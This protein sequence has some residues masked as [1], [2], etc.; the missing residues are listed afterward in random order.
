LS[1]IEQ[2]LHFKR[3]HADCI[4][5]YLKKSKFVISKIKE[6]DLIIC[7]SLLAFS[8][9]FFKE[10]MAHQQVLKMTYVAVVALAWA[11]LFYNYDLGKS[12]IWVLTL[13]TAVNLYKLLVPTVQR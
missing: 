12:F 4:L 5:A 1:R 8:L 7:V 13:V 9:T 6:M 11:Y 10:R 2:I 3:A